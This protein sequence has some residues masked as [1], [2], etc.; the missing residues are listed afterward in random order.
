MMSMHG[1]G[2][3]ISEKGN[4][5]LGPSLLRPRDFLLVPFGAHVPYVIRGEPSE[6]L[7]RLVGEAYIHGIMD[8]EVGLKNSCNGEMVGEMFELA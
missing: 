6:K 2:P 5:G 4:V 8:D 7:W 3:F 1:S